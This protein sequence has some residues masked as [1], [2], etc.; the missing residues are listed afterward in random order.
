MLDRLEK[1]YGTNEPIFTKE[2]MEIMNDYSKSRIFQILKKLEEEKSIINFDTGIYYI[3]Q[4]TRFGLSC[5]STEQV[6][7]KKYISN[8][9]EVFGIYSGLSLK[10]NFLMT[11]QVPSTIEIV[12]NNETMIVREC[13][14]NGRRIILRKSRTLINRD[15]VSAYTILELFSDMDIEKYLE[16]H[17]AQREVKEYIK[18]NKVK[19]KDIVDLINNFPSK[20]IK[21]IIRGGLMNDFA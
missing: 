21:N 19:M 8:N 20:T 5:I 18:E 17:S 11:Y 9:D 15:N 1:K 14:I 4:K 10:L 13:M 16:N 12:T 6:V 7:Q 3:P 2:I